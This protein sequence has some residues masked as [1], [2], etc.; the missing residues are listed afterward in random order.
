MKRYITRTAE[1]E[2][3]PTWNELAELFW[4][5]NAH[6]QAQF[7]NH[8]GAIAET[9]LCFQLQ[10]ISDSPMLNGTGRFA[11]SQIGDYSV[12]IT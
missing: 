12:E 8:L 4:G 6:D 3:T 9:K 5:M 1:I 2:V 11:M 7:F 10:F